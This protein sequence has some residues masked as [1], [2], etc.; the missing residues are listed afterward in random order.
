MY[1]LKL[2][3]LDLSLLVTHPKG[4]EIQKETKGSMDNKAESCSLVHFDGIY[5]VPEKVAGS[6]S[7]DSGTLSRG[8]DDSYK[9]LSLRVQKQVPVLRVPNGI[10]GSVE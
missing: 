10:S 5:D 2:P 8:V 1:F 3:R 4:I 6:Q 7:K 9:L